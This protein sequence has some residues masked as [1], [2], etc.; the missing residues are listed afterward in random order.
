MKTGEIEF[1]P[2]RYTRIFLEWME[3]IREWCLAAS[4]GG[5]TGFR[6]YYTEDGTACAA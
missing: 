6:S 5:A 1:Y 4:F 3:N 2:E